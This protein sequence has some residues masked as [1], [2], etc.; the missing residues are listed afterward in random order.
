MTRKADAVPAALGLGG[1]LLTMAACASQSPALV[2]PPATPALWLAAGTPEAPLREWPATATVSCDQEAS[3]GL[4][5]D[6]GETSELETIT[7]TTNEFPRYTSD[8]LDDELSFRWAND[9]LSLGSIAVGFT[10]EGRLINAVPFPASEDGAWTLVSTEGAFGTA[11]TVSYV[12]AAA[13]RVKQLHPEAPP[14][15]INDTSLK[16][17]GWFPPHRAHQNGR[18]VDLGF[19]FKPTPPDCRGCGRVF[20]ASLNW[21]LI[22]SIVILGDV[23]TI[24]V[25]RRIQRVLYQ[26][27]L[28]EGEDP[29]WLDS[30][31][32]SDEALLEH[33]P[34]HRDHFHV[35]Y[36]NPRAQELG[37]RLASALVVEERERSLIVR[38][39]S[40][41]SLSVIAARHRSS[42]QTIKKANR[43]RG[44]FLRAGQVLRVPV[45]GPC[46]DCPVP[47]PVQVPA[48]RLPGG[49]SASLF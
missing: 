45:R 21:E 3:A 47:R 16:E 35:R 4:E 31:F 41:D 42:I 12:T 48:R 32:R 28:D 11:E 49:L 8:L 33:A 25:D 27:A 39:R 1:V 40:G 7:S 19:Y 44:T 37:V 15:R 38:V 23:E 43:L 6:S 2:M 10:H 30:L 46:T 5:E 17:G 9:P 36:F 14:L 20:D 22:K 29:A 26:A 13:N 24:L 34:R 18:E